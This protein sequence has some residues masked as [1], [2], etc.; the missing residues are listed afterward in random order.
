MA[1]MPTDASSKAYLQHVQLRLR[2]DG[3]A[4]MKVELSA[5]TRC[6]LRATMIAANAG[7]RSAAG[8]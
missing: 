2:E 8:T 6:W 3:V 1:S 5:P 7:I 4:V